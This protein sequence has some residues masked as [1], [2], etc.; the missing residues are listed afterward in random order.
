MLRI[1]EQAL[2]PSRSDRNVVIT[3]LKSSVRIPL[4]HPISAFHELWF[5]LLSK[6]FEYQL[7]AKIWR[8]CAGECCSQVETHA[9]A[10]QKLS[11][12]D[13]LASTR[14]RVNRPDIP[15][16]WQGCL[17]LCE[18]KLMI[19]HMKYLHRLPRILNSAEQKA[20]DVI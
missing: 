19:V 12:C 1:V 6:K 16:S 7:E 11:C 15:T 13:Q 10:A 18:P 9:Q 3:K 14:V 4:V 20:I 2:S 5:G 17:L 8:K